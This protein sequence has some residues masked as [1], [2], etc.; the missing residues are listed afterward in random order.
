MFT[1]VLTK[2]LRS[3]SIS[4]RN[5][6][7][8]GISTMQ[9]IYLSNETFEALAAEIAALSPCAFTGRVTAD[10]VKTVLGE[11]G[12]VWPEVVRTPTAVGNLLG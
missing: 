5:R 4:R 3:E 8:R 10:Q 1:D 6:A 11:V 12:N 2:S 9:A 7:R